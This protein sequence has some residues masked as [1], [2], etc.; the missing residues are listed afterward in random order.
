[1]NPPLR[2]IGDGREDRTKYDVVHFAWGGEQV[3]VP[4]SNP[5]NFEDVKFKI[6]TAGGHGRGM[7]F[8][9]ASEDGSHKFTIKADDFKEK[10]E[11]VIT[12]RYK[13][14]HKVFCHLNW[15][16]QRCWC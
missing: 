3:T 15:K 5:K 16:I 10:T 6:F 11:F 13:K 7:A 1:M 12:Q 2:V 8:R 4:S 9:F 14:K